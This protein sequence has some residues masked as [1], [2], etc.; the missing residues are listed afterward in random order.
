MNQL[1]ISVRLTFKKIWETKTGRELLLL[2]HSL[3][4]RCSSRVPG[5]SWKSGTQP[6]PHTWMAGTQLFRSALDA[7][8]VRHVL[9]AKI[10][11]EFK[12]TQASRPTAYYKATYPPHRS[13]SMFLRNNIR[14][15]GETVHQLLYSYWI[16]PEL[17][18]SL[19]IILIR[20]VRA[21]CCSEESKHGRQSRQR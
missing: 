8:R 7:C 14:N 10:R 18:Q 15:W 16:W 2:S 9:E 12:L 21:K 17:M 19:Q 5:W 11:A 6:E 4:P 1:H 13:P 20:D 3:M